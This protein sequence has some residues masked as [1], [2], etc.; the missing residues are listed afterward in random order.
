M[1]QLRMTPKHQYKG[2]K[3]RLQAGRQ[4]SMEQYASRHFVRFRGIPCPVTFD[5]VQRR[6]ADERYGP[7]AKGASQRLAEPKRAR[8]RYHL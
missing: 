7:Q 2:T 5:F 4:L 6:R 8:K 3:C 1:S